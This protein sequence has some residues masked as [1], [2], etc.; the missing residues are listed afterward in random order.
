MTPTPPLDN[1]THLTVATWVAELHRAG[2]APQDATIAAACDALAQAS[3]S[4]VGDA[5]GKRL[6]EA[7]GA[8]LPDND[9]AT[10]SALAQALYGASV[11]TQMGEGDR[12]ARTSRIRK[13]QFTRR[14]PWLARI[15][16]RRSD[17]SVAP[18]WLVIHGC[19]DQVH[20]LD[21]NPWDDIDEQRDLPLA[22]FLVLWE[23]D[24]CASVSVI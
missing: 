5:A 8:H 3:T 23:L 17:G 24:D 12:Q 6:V 2:L 16:E 10:I 1:A 11:S 4:E 9:P 13:Y 18:G 19:T 22:D 14:L 21:P 15:F 7:I 20:A